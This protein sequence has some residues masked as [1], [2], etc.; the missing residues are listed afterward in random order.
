MLVNATTYN[1]CTQLDTLI[2][3]TLINESIDAGYE[4][5]LGSLFVVFVLWVYTPPRQIEEFNDVLFFSQC[6]AVFQIPKPAPYR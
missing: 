3:Q 2:V 4:Y 6:T 1:I 5:R